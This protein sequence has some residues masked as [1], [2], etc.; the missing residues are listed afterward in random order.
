MN[1][2]TTLLLNV[3]KM[4]IALLLSFFPLQQV[5]AQDAGTEKTKNLR[6]KMVKETDG[7]VQVID[8]TM[9]V[10]DHAELLQAIKGLELDTTMLRR[11]NA[12]SLGMLRFDTTMKMTDIN[13]V[14]FNSKGGMLDTAAFRALHGG[15]LKVYKLDRKMRNAEREA[16]LRQ[17]REHSVDTV[18]AR[19]LKGSKAVYLRADSAT[20]IHGFRFQKDGDVV[21][22]RTVHPDVLF[23]AARDSARGSIFRLHR[24]SETLSAINPNHIE[25]ITVHKNSRAISIDSLFSPGATRVQL[26]VKADEKTGETKVYKIN[27]DGKEEEVKADYLKLGRGNARVVIHLKARIED[28]T[29]DDK[30]ALKEAGAAVETRKKNELDVEEI[31]F[32]PNPN[33][34]RFNL[35]F[36]L[37]DKGTTRV[38][39][40]DSRGEEV[41]VD[42]VEGLS[43]QYNRQI[44]LTPFG[45]GIYYLQI[46]QGRKHHTKKIL[47]Q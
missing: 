45:P 36:S 3:V 16:L 21:K 47:V 28:I 35:S 9:Q 8:T 27:E 20:Q 10:A 19:T 4:A 30:E 15:K 39:V 33:N 14:I 31:G 32:Y 44:D 2:L 34:G 37:E 6:I 41:F 1:T 12:G 38:S 25:K 23:E 11:L 18:L 17:L 29:A 42:T 24:G 7:E 5:A 22:F 43:G 26:S 40:M 46:A 13:T